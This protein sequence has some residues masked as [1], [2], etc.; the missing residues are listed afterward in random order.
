MSQY[1]SEINE[2]DVITITPL[3]VECV[4]V[5]PSTNVSS[6]GAASLFIQGG[7]PPYS[8]VWN[9]NGNNV[10]GQ[11]QINLSVGEYPAT[12]VDY[13]GDYSAS[14][15]CV[16]T[17]ETDCSFGVSITYPNPEIIEQGFYFYDVEITGGTSIGPYTIYYTTVSSNNIAELYPLGVA[18]NIT[19]SELQ[20]GITIK[21]PENNSLVIVYNQLCDTV[22][23]FTVE[24]Q[25]ECVDLCITYSGEKQVQLECNGVDQ[26][27]IFKWI[28]TSTPNCEVLWDNDNHR[29]YLTCP[30]NGDSLFSNDPSNSNPPIN[31]FS[32]GGGLI[33]PIIATPGSCQTQQTLT[34]N[35]SVGQPECDCDGTITITAN[36]GTPPYQYSINNGLTQQSSPLFTSLC[37][38]NYSYQVTDSLNNSSSGV[39]ILNPLQPNTTY[40]ISLQITPTTIT[41]NNQQLNEEYVVDVIVSPPL[42]NG[43]TITFDLI[44]LG[45][46]RNSVN[47]G[48][49][50][51]NRTVVLNKNGNPLTLTTTNDI[52]YTE[53]TTPQ[54]NSDNSTVQFTAT[55]N[56][57]NGITITQGDI[58]QLMVSSVITYSSSPT[59]CN[60]GID[61]NQFTITNPSVVGCGC[62]DV[63]VGIPG[64]VI[65][66]I[67]PGPSFNLIFNTL[68]T[69]NNL[70]TGV[71]GFNYSIEQAPNPLQFSQG[72]YNG[73]FVSFFVNLTLNNVPAKIEIFKNNQLLECRDL[74]GLGTIT[75]SFTFPQPFNSSLDTLEIGLSD[76]TC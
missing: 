18:Q 4:V 38:G 43:V 46:F 31:W 55:T 62:C 56:N 16:L 67:D 54:C 9:I 40:E 49:S 69:A 24:P 23:T 25:V 72:V 13:Y 53:P 71:I 63:E 35:V 39:V 22:Q 60:F 48:F 37:P 65:E 30:L 59:T 28:G 29:W 57:W 66:P 32:V 73:E 3:T 6:D 36:G 1:P 14:T 44:H 26:N 2:C 68:G 70:I 33:G 27:G 8:I 75:Q 64:L 34:Q 7:T 10:L 17:G 58:I 41:N 74:F 50:N 47:P 52:T 15:I 20:S 76:G 51:L 5:H 19:L 21:I 61:N 45:E 11:N 12:V 42:P